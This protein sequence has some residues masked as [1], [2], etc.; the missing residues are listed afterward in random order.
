MSGDNK[1]G[2]MNA[3]FRLGYI[4]SQERFYETALEYY[5]V[6]ANYGDATAMHNIGVFYE[7]GFGVEKDLETAKY[8]YARARENGYKDSK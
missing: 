4:Y 1:N 7:R 5:R 8:W 6:A 3:N 2:F